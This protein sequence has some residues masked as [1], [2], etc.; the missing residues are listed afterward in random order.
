LCL[1][2]KGVEQSLAPR[3]TKLDDVMTPPSLASIIQEIISQG[4][5]SSGNSL[6][7]HIFDNGSSWTTTSYRK[8]SAY[9]FTLPEPELVIEWNSATPTPTP[10]PTPNP[11]ATPTPDPTST[12]DATLDQDT[13]DAIWFVAVLIS[14]MSGVVLYTKLRGS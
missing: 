2:G 13:K 9:E 12:P 6:L 8:F 4:S 1:F 3:N 14:F 7:L 5:W 10:S 11:T